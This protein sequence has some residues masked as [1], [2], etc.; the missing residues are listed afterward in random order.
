MKDSHLTKEQHIMKQDLQNVT[1]ANDRQVA[2]THYT[3]E[4]QHWDFVCDTGLHYLLANATKYITRWR[5]KN[6]I[7]DLQKSLH[8]IEKAKERF[9]S[10]PIFSHKIVDFINQFP[11]EDRDIMMSI[12]EGMY[13]KAHQK[14]QQLIWKYDGTEE[15]GLG[16]VNQD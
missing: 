11:V 9:I 13:D 7:Q 12:C 1:S 8:Y 2:G 10:P 3:L 5:K 6:G 14:I 16:Y 15:A 4:Y